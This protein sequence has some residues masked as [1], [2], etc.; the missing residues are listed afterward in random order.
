MRVTPE[1]AA[2]ISQAMLD[3]NGDKVTAA[4][5]V[6][7]PKRSLELAIRDTPEL[8]ARWG[9]KPKGPT[10]IEA[11]SRDMPEVTAPP[12]PGPGLMHGDQVEEQLRLE[13]RK[14][15]ERGLA[16]IGLTPNE[17]E[18]AMALQSLHN[19]HMMDS[20]S[21][22]GGSVTK[23]A[24]KLMTQ[25]SALE[26][27]LDWAR[28]K[29]DQFRESPAERDRYLGEE[30]RLMVRYLEICGE[31]RKMSELSN[32]YLTQMALIKWSKNNKPRD[33]KSAKKPGYQNVTEMPIAE[34]Q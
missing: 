30:D 16:G 13:N 7:M 33:M 6:G 23:C 8:W 24:M 18:E 3:R 4:K 29:L 31:I 26:M 11:L 1:N 25:R 2:L 28:Q 10:Q 21:A 22:I 12:P 17:L 27:R 14:L 9:D 34:G 15:F 20:F 32:R 19:R 5:L